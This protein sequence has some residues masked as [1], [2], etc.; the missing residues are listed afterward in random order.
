M[1]IIRIAY[2]S[3]DE[4]LMP[5]YERSLNMGL[6]DLEDTIISRAIIRGGIHFYKYEDALILISLCEQH[7]RKILGIDSFIVSKSATSL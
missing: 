1:I 2:Y 5:F 4:V 7:N 6:S 3:D